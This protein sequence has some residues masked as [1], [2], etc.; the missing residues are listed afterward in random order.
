MKNISRRKFL[1]STS[2]TLLGSAFSLGAFSCS[3]KKI[4]RPN[5]VFFLTDDQRWDGM[6]CAGNKILETPNMDRMADE[7]I[8][9]E[10]MFVTNS[11]CGPSRACYLTGKYSHNHGVWI[12]SA[13]EQR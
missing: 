1:R 9:F 5:F 11:L 3:Q 2:L 4:I 12:Q 6:S 10:N 13:Q 7:G 8:R